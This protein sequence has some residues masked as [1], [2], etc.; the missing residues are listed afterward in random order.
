MTEQTILGMT[1]EQLKNT[2]PAVIDGDSFAYIIG[3]NHKDF[4]NVD[5]VI[6]NVDEFINTILQAVQTRLIVGVLNPRVTYTDRLMGTE[7]EPNFRHAIAVTKPYKGN[8]GEKPEWY[9]KWQLVIEDRLITQWGFKRV[10]SNMEADDMVAS[11]MVLLNSIEGCTPV[12]CGCD[13]DLRQIPGHHYNY[14]KNTGDFLT[15]QQALWNLFVQLMMGDST[16]N[17]PGLPGT[18]PKGAERILAT[19]GIDE[20]TYHIAVLQ[21]FTL[22][23]GIDEG[24]RLFYESYMLCALRTEL[25]TS[26]YKLQP[27]DLDAGA[28]AQMSTEEMPEEAHFDPDLD[29]EGLFKVEV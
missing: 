29:D 18:G 10:P 17:I 4:D 23:F 20:S 9:I 11:L 28:V 5:E 14:R 16:D 3:Y 27:Y 7:P 6:R 2:R 22:K 13:K 24:I 26:E 15:P 8:R 21:A 25:D 1:A 12:C 19:E